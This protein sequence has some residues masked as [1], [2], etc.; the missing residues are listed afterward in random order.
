VLDSDT[1][2]GKRCRTA[3]PSGANDD[4]THIDR[5][6]A[7]IWFLQSKVLTSRDLLEMTSEE[8][9][10]NKGHDHMLS[11]EVVQFL[12][13]LAK[14]K[15]DL[16]ARAPARDPAHLKGANGQ[17]IYLFCQQKSVLL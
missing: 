14:P 3:T 15:S 1:A 16:F 9:A 8:V 2:S 12:I 7:C 10:R 17:N 11:N 13:V 4:A 5:G 6:T